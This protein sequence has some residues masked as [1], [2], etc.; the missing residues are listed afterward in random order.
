MKI[1]LTARGFL[2][3]DFKDS[4]G[5]ACSI[6]ESSIATE[7]RLWLGCDEGE[8]VHGLCC[9]RM[10]LTQ[11]QAAELIPLLKNFVKTG[12][13]PAKITEAKPKGKRK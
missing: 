9:A 8:H 12:L 7:Y 4:N 3:G 5:I 1:E 2:R 10:H 11:T 13:L 6:Q